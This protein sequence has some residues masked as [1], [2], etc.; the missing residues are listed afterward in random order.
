MEEN[1]TNYLKEVG[2]IDNKSENLILSLYKI[3]YYNYLNYDIDKIKF[4]E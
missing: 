2:I 4:N 1:F 3:K